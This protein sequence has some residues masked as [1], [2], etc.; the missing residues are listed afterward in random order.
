M[1]DVRLL[2]AVELSFAGAP[3]RFGAPSRALALLAY[4]ALRRRPLPRDAVA[5][6]LWPDAPEEEAHANLRRHLYALTKALP[7]ADGVPWLVADKKSVGWNPNAPARVDVV[8]F[9]RLAASEE[10]LEEAVRL[11]RGPFL[12]GVDDEWVEPERE[13]LRDLAIGALARLTARERDPL[14]AAGYAQQLLRIDPWREDALRDLIRLRHASGDRAG[15]LREYREFAERLV[16]E[17]GVAPMPETTA[18]YERIASGTAPPPRR[19]EAAVEARRTNLPAPATPLLGRGEA[20]GELRRALG[21]TRLLTLVGTGGIGKTR[22][23]LQLGADSLDA[24]A[25][26]VWLVDLATAGDGAQAAAALGAAVGVDESAADAPLEAAV[27]LLRRKQALLL[28]DNCEHVASDAA[29]AVAAIL[30]GCPGVRVL[31][32]ARQPLSVAGER[33]YRVPSLEGEDAVALFV[34][35]AQA[36]AAGFAPSARERAAIAEICRRLDGIPLAIELAAAR[37]KIFDVRTIAARL[38]ERFRLLTGGDA[39]LPRHRT[40]RALID[41]GY[42]LLPQPERVLF[43]RLA[44]FSGGWTLEAVERVCA[45]APLEP[46]AA[47]ELL[48]AL[49]D[50]SFVLALPAAGGRRYRMRESIRAYALERLD[51]SGER[52]ALERRHA[53][54]FAAFGRRVYETFETMPDAAWF[55]LAASELDNVRAAL[56][57]SL[58]GGNDPVLGARLAADYGTF[59]FLSANRTDRRWAQIAYERLDRAA[60]PALATRLSYEI[61]THSLREPEHARWIVAAARDGEDPG[62][63]ADALVLQAELLTQNERF[64]EAEAALEEALQIYLPSRRRKSNVFALRAYGE[65][66]LAQGRFEDA[67]A[68]FERA[69][70]AGTALEASAVTAT[71]LPALAESDFAAGALTRACSRALQ[72]REAIGRWF[73][74]NLDFARVTGNL[75]AY[76]L[77]AGDV[78]A[79][80]GYA[81]EALDIAVDLGFRSAAIVLLEHAAVI[82]GLQGDLE[83]AARL[84]GF[85]DAARRRRGLGRGPAERAGQE[86][87]AAVLAGRYSAEELRQRMA[88]GA[89]MGEARAVAEAFLSL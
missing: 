51:E 35:R 7:A 1:L 52:A 29:R 39:T 77:A 62:L 22:L 40:M 42:E 4:L 43:A 64:A 12:A 16:R 30:A 48:A 58:G 54:V 49:V 81:R 38:N 31:A 5:F 9:E 75:A 83:R 28:L 23:A 27:R 10:A 37:V 78:E 8:E 21:E 2:G 44:V 71:V 6:T 46:S 33:E 3:V 11:Y 45:S 56:E 63:L 84:S 53:E 67:R 89:I 87:L 61:A 55:A 50:K 70:E 57:W 36:V 76:A 85:T 86:R 24:F 14:R 73:G 66:R 19:V 72:A 15:A 82:A 41:W 60:Q 59:W 68:L 80:R 69:L 65:L 20:L 13:R 88:E 74:G 34:A 25:D 79:A 18:L 32:T 26:G 47:L 17:I